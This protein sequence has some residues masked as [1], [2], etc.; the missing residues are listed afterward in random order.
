[1][2]QKEAE[3]IRPENSRITPVR[4]ALQ[5]FFEKQE[6]PVDYAQIM[7]YLEKN[8]LKVNKTTVYRQLDF[9]LEQGLIQE[10]D[11]GEGKKR[12]ELKKE[13]HH[14][15]ICTDCNKVECIEI[16]ENFKGQEAEINKKTNFKISG[17]MLE[18]FGQCGSCQRKTNK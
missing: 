4:K 13:H 11:F 10:L 2:N 8:A 9:L 17:H 15:L 6:I 7:A 16:K 14:H 1:M 3:K 5:G 18:F 12:Y